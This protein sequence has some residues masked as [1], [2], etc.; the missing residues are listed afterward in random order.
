MVTRTLTRTEWLAEIKTR[1]D[2]A[3]MADH[4]VTA[5]QLGIQRM[6]EYRRAARRAMRADGLSY[7]Y[8]PQ[9]REQTAQEDER[10]CGKARRHGPA[11][12]PAHPTSAHKSAKP[13][14]GSAP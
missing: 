11:H 5:D 13:K 6:S 9:E 8:T 2:A 7:A 12:S 10:I 3:A 14:P 4:S 1:A